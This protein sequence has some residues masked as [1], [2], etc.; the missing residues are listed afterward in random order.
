MY[1]FLLSFNISTTCILELL[2]VDSVFQMKL[3]DIKATKTLL[4]VNLFKFKHF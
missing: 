2:P 1:T 4:R 3:L